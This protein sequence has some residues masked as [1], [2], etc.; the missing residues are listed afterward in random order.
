MDDCI[1]QDNASPPE[2]GADL[3]R[4]ESVIAAALDV[5]T[6][7]DIRG[8]VQEIEDRLSSGARLKFGE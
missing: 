6:V 1:F 5:L 4:R 8:L 2:T 7:E 3:D